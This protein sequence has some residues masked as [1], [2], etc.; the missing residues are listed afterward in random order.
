MLIF[1]FLCFDAESVNQKVKKKRKEEPSSL[2]QRQRV[3]MLLTELSQKF[4]P[5]S[6]PAA[7]QVQPA[8]ASTGPMDKFGSVLQTVLY[9][10]VMTMCSNEH[11]YCLL[12]T[13]IILASTTTLEFLFN[14]SI[15]PE[16]IPG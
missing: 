10:F 8:A 5:K 6:F 14:Q 16:I 4:P 9:Q 7:H 15:F 2:F 13:F 1:W 11:L 12:S 3:D